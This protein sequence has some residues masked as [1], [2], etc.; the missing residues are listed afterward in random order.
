[1]P[2]FVSFLRGWR[3][4]TCRL[5]GRL[6]DMWWKLGI[7]G[8]YRHTISSVIDSHWLTPFHVSV[9]AT[10]VVMTVIIFTSTGCYSLRHVK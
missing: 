4:L 1:M 8:I 3:V 7:F 9:W 6:S 5:T 10:A 2:L